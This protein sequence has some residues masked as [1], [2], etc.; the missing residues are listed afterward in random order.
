MLFKASRLRLSAARLA[1]VFFT[2]PLLANCSRSDGTTEPTGSPGSIAVV[3]GQSQTGTV[4]TTLSVPLTVTVK[5]VSGNLLANATVSW[6]VSPGAGATS[7]GAT[8]TDSR[9]V[10][11]VTWT[12]G[13]SAGASSVSAQVGGVS[14]VTFTAT[15][16][17]GAA[18]GVVALPDVLSLGIG[19]T[20]TATATARDQYG[21]EISGSTLTFSTPDAAI[22][23]VSATGLITA[24]SNGMA[25]IV[26]SVG[27]K[28]DTI[29]VTVSVAGTSP[30]GTLA[31]TTM[32]PGQVITP[33]I[34][35]S[36]A[37]ICLSSVASNSEYGLIAYSSNTT[38]ATTTLF[39]VYGLGL[40]TPTAPIL[41]SSLSAQPSFDLGVATIQAVPLQIDR[42]AE[43]ARREI[44]RREL[45]PL[46][47]VAR[48]TFASRATRN[49]SSSSF[50]NLAL[51]APSVGDTIRLN[52]QALQGCTNAAIKGGVV[53]AVGSKSIVVADT[54]NPIN[55]YSSADYVSIAATFDTLV[56]PVDVDNF[57]APTDVSGYGKIILFFTTAVNQLT[58]KSAGFVIGG[59]FF[60][61]DLYPKV[62]KNGL[63]GCA[64]SNEAEMFYL[65]VPDPNGTINSNPRSTADVTRLNL[66]T[67]AHEFQHLINASHRLYITPGAIAS[68]E[69]WLDEGLSHTAEELLYFKISGFGS[70]DNLNLQSVAGTTAQ[71]TNFTSYM[72]QNFGRFYERLKAPEITSPYAT[73]DSLS[74]RGAT[75]NFLRYAAGRQPAGTEN[76]FF[77]SIVNSATAGL[78]NLANVLPNGQLTQYFADW[79]V[80]TFADDYPSSPQ[81]QLDARYKY[82]SWNFRNIYPN[83]RIG[84]GSSLG[85][86]PLA[87]R[88]L[89]SNASQRLSLAGGGA[90]YLRFAVPA[91]KSSVIS[92]STNGAVPATALKFSVVRLR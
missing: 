17:P 36:S 92:W 79:S 47:D 49:T 87:V 77:R 44:E 59:F 68:E 75:W 50:S 27:T 84:G 13:T 80:A 51:A 46:V 26:V 39:D 1:L 63:Q 7:S 31:A 45:T 14:P 88:T 42:S 64:G 32:I 82:P 18:T 90:G 33:A 56:Y 3:S 37:R 71:S 78:A 53:K 83:L 20:L 30:C 24:I 38:F 72:A 74:T 65:L 16:L 2:G 62:A 70:R 22:A 29:P 21:N 52:T 40:A 10:S 9:G 69:T 67:L 35:G 48:E 54:A 15:A 6:D 91:G 89:R 85:V 58:P 41:A 76:T 11:S 81:D 61:R 34:V 86:Y 60:S 25:R 28:A 73:N 66:S 43:I 23:T 12:L 19:D 57:G 8:R 5:D 4:G 55:G